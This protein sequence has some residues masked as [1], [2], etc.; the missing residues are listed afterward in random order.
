VCDG[1]AVMD[2]MALVSTVEDNMKRFTDREVKKAEEARRLQ[3]VLGYPSD[4]ALVRMISS[5]G[6]VNSPI[7]VHDVYNAVRIWGPNLGSL[8]GKTTRSKPN[9][10]TIEHLDEKIIIDKEIVLCMD[11]FFVEGISFLMTISR[12]LNLLTAHHIVDRGAK[13]LMNAYDEAFDVYASKGF[14]IVNNLFDARVV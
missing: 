14:K 4:K 5:G 3:T 10:V 2:S 12:K 1:R 6:M 9:V 8:K 13:S 7:S 11:I